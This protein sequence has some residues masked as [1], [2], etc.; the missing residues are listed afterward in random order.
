MIG[1]YFRYTLNDKYAQGLDFDAALQITDTFFN[2]D[3]HK[4]CY[5]IKSITGFEGYIEKEEFD[6]RVKYGD[7]VEVDEEQWK[8]ISYDRSEAIKQHYTSHNI[9]PM[10][11]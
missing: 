7:Y 4:E 10:K 6:F 1:K 3:I 2:S 9:Y 5:L 11:K 8:Q